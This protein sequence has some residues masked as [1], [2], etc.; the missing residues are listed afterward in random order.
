MP[1]SESL[2]CMNNRV[3][4]ILWAQWRI[5]RNYL[6]RSNKAGLLFTS[7]LGVLWYGSFISVATAAGFLFANPDDLASI[8]KILPGAL[9]LAFLYW[10][11]VPLLLMS[12]GSAVDSRKLLV[13]P[14][15]ASQL[16]GL[17]VLLR[18]TIC[19][20]ILI[21]MSGAGVGLLLNPAIPWWA[22]L[23]LVVYAIFN[24]LLSVGIRD[25][26]VRLLARKLIRELAIFAFVLA[27]AIPQFLLTTG[28]GK[29]LLHRLPALAAVPWPWISTAGLAEGHF[30]TAHLLGLLGW[31][32]AAYVFSRWQFER[33]LRFDPSEQ[34][35]P[36]PARASATDWVERFLR[37]PSLLFADPTGALIEKE[38]RSL[39]RSSR[40]RLVFL[41]GFSF[42]LLIWLPMTF[43]GARSPDSW[44]SL[45]YLAVVSVYSLVLLSDVLFWNSF[46]FDRGAAQI[47][48]LAPLKIGT[49]ITAKNLTAFFL[50]LLEV[51]LVA[52][53]CAVLR[54]QVRLQG[55]IEAYA[56]TLTV[57][58]FLATAGNLSSIYNAK[59]VDPSNSFRSNAGRHT[60]A[61]L[62][63]FFP[64]SLIPVA[65]AYLARYAFRSDVAFAAVLGFGALLGIVMHRV[66]RESA[67]EAAEV[68]KELF[69]G[70]LSRTSGPIS[71]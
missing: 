64:V 68:R 67:V 49:V 43:G 60:Q 35:Q 10:Q 9:L 71:S 52:A 34:A 23:S 45:N 24:L 47:Y 62:M 5:F 11:V 8:A 14:I 53:V 66:S 70:A 25:L 7:V 48:F 2:A 26:L 22:P 19:G 46:G 56:V 32:V 12:T 16:F 18:I 69:I 51:S 21:V 17:E 63:L 1:L 29:G 31:T 54:F 59:P 57:S 41:M 44:M 38:L 61:V 55:L 40:F 28:S 20:D 27:A 4:A 13:Y 39:V 36:V 3:Q 58:L 50:I 65:L 30:K 37:I 42:G 6:P 33:G 15:P